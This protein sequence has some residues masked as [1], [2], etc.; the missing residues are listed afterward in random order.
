MTFGLDIDRCCLSVLNDLAAVADR[1]RTKPPTA[2]EYASITQRLFGDS[3]D[4]DRHGVD[5][6]TVGKTCFPWRSSSADQPVFSTRLHRDGRHVSG[7]TL[8]AAQFEVVSQCRSENGE[9]ANAALSAELGESFMIDRHLR[10]HGTI[11]IL[12]A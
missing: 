6:R 8:D 3:V 5:A 4:G 1:L 10:P 12:R 7:L 2:E 9:P 11:R